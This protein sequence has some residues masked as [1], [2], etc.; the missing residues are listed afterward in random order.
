MEGVSP[1]PLGEGGEGEEGAQAWAGGG[2]VRAPGVT[3]HLRLPQAGES[4]F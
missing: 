3:S 2:H 4:D 1:P